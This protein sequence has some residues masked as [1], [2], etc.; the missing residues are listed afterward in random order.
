M[1][2]FVCSMSST[3]QNRTQSTRRQHFG[4]LEKPA[5]SQEGTALSLG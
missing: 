2:V 3:G 4:M 5:A 1:T